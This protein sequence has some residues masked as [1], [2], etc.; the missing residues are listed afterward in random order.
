LKFTDSGWEFL[1][2]AFEIKKEIKAE[3]AV[4]LGEDGMNTLRDLLYQLLDR[5]S[6]TNQS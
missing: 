3:Y 6:N 5:L 1:Q 4:I 2:D